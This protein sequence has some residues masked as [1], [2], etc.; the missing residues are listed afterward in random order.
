M[1]RVVRQKSWSGDTCYCLFLLIKSMKPKA[2]TARVSSNTKLLVA[3]V[4]CAAYKKI[5]QGAM[6]SKSARKYFKFRKSNRGGRFQAKMAE[7][8]RQL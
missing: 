4:D 2:D 5:T 8:E 1:L 7:N 3:P 6:S